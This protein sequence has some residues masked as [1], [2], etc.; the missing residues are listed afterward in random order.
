MPK[1]VLD[2][3]ALWLSNKLLQIP[4]Q[5]RAEYANLIPLALANGTF[6]CDA[7]KVWARVYIYNRPSVTLQAVEE[8]LEAFEQAKMLFRWQAEDGSKWGYW[9]GIDKPGRL[10][11]GNAKEHGAKGQPVPQDLLKSFIS[12]GNDPDKG[13]P[14]DSPHPDSVRKMSGQGPEGVRSGFGFGLG[15]GN[16]ISSEAIASDEQVSKPT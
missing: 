8:M 1:R 11:S 5:Y 9:V 4:E 7:R 2:G 14:V 12:D 16:T 6:E 3:E 15:S 10:P 13:Q